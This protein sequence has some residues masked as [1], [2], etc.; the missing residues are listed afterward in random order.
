M[1]FPQL[2]NV[3]AATKVVELVATL[4]V[5]THAIINTIVA[6]VFFENI[7]PTTHVVSIHATTTS[8]ATNP[9]FATLHI[10]TR[11]PLLNYQNQFG[12]RRLLL[13]YHAKP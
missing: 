8:I 9:F 10:D 7:I 6:I 4:V 2:W 1:L 13:R 11:T 12:K 3:V 5:V